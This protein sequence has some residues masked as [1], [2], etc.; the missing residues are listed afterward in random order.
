MPAAYQVTEHAMTSSSSAPAAP[1]CARPWA[2]PSPGSRPPASPRCSRPAAIPSRRRAGS[3]PRS[4]TWSADDWRWHMYDTVKGSDWLGDQDAIEYMCRNAIPAVIE[5]EHFGVPFSR[6]EA[7]RIYQRPFGG[8]MMDYGDGDPAQARLR[9]RRPHRARDHP[10]PLSA[11][12]EAQRPVFCRIFR[13]RPDHRRGR[14]LPRRHGLGP[15]RRHPPPVPRAS[16]DPR[17]RRL[18]PRLFLVHLGPYLH[19]RRQRDGVARRTA[20]AGHGVRPVPPDRHLWCRLPDHRGC[21]RRRRVSD[22]QRG[23]ALYGGL[24]A[25]RQGP[26]LARRRQPGDDDRDPR[27]PRLRPVEGSHPPASRAS[28]ARGAASAAA[29]H[30]AKPRRSF[31]KST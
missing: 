10:H 31:P 12:P 2:A 19:R 25:A 26:R 17:D 29:R 18:R 21:A 1:G 13:A 23:R 5:L 22:Q 24:R 27:G 6:T 9:R 16:R 15:R 11:V 28:L 7:G 14:R 3:P 4:A 20:V 30:H 8:H